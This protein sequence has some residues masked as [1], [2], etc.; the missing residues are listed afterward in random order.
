MSTSV[1]TSLEVFLTCHLSLSNSFC[2]LSHLNALPVDTLKVDR[3]FI[4]NI[5][6]KEND[7]I[8]SVI[9]NLGHAMNLRVVAQGVESDRHLRALKTLGIDEAQGFYVGP[10]VAAE[11]IVPLLRQGIF[12]RLQAASLVA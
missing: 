5:D 1:L 10:P 7:S 3:S 2:S 4:R 11:E 6:R 12:G 9:A 8:Y